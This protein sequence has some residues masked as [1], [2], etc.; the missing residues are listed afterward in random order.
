MKLSLG[1]MSPVKYQQHLG[2]TT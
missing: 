2:I 1:A